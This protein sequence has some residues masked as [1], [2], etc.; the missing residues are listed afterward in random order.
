MTFMREDSE[1][2]RQYV[3]EG[4]N[5]AFGKLVERHCNLV[6][7]AAFRILGDANLARDVAQTTFATLARKAARLPAKVVLAGWL[8]QAARL[9][10]SMMART[11]SRRA[12]REE[13]AMQL[14]QL[15]QSTPGEEKAVKE[16]QPLL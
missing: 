1:L 16:L 13:N 6:W 4:S 5:E 2:L 9:S 7:C 15:L 10:A 12:Q 14:Q 11:E 3:N 8:Y